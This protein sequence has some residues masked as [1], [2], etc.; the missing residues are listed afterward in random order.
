MPTSNELGTSTNLSGNLGFRLKY[1]FLQVND[2]LYK[3]QNIKIGQIENPL[4]PWAEDLY[5]YR[6]VNLVPL[7]YLAYSSTDLGIAATG[8]IMIDGANYGDYWFG[9]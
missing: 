2:V 9:I 7:N 4:V 1:G 6:F 5:G 8:P 3:D